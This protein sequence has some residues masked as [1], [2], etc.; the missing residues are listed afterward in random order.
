MITEATMDTR[1]TKSLAAAA[2]ALPLLA[3]CGAS[4]DPAAPAGSSAPA[5]SAAAPS[6]SA[7]ASPAPSAAPS[8]PEADVKDATSTFVKQAFTVRYSERPKDYGARVKPLVTSSIYPKLMKDINLDENLVKAR[9]RFGSDARAVAKVP[10]DVK[11]TKLGSATATTKVTFTIQIQQPKGDGWKTVR[12]SPE[13]T[14]T[15]KLVKDGDDWL[16]DDLD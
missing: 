16:V 9:A 15:I 8:D 12:K 3:G 11:V 13:E 6:S 14:A 5:S 7:A 1:I 10:D 4:S 2:L